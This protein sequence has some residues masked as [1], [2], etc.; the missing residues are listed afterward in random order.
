VL[1][2]KNKKNESNR[3]GTQWADF[4]NLIQIDPDSV[5]GPVAS[6][7]Q[8]YSL[9]SFPPPPSLPL[10][11]CYM[12]SGRK[13]RESCEC[14]GPHLAHSTF[15]LSCIHKHISVTTGWQLGTWERGWL[16]FGEVL[17]S[18]R[19]QHSEYPHWGSW[20]TSIPPD[21]FKDNTLN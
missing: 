21:K 8:H 14:S 2:T 5:F 4:D 3:L 15:C 18:N 17:G 19:S 16:A 6:E 1:P 12:N 20:F 13:Q 10:H 7:G 11:G 9:I